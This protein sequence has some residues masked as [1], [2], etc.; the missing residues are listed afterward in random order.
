MVLQGQ[1]YSVKGNEPILL[2]DPQRILVVQCGSMAL[3]AATVKDGA[4]EGTRRYLCSINQGR[5]FSDV[6][7]IST[8][9]F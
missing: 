5:H 4:I 9:R 1:L 6:R 3:F 8:V 2:N 7:A